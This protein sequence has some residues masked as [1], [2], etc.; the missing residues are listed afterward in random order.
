[1]IEFSYLML[2][3][4]KK[5]LQQIDCTAAFSK[6]QHISATCPAEGM[7]DRLHNGAIAN[8]GHVS[9]TVQVHRHRS[10]ILPRPT[11][12]QVKGKH[13][14]DF[15]FPFYGHWT[16]IASNRR[17]WSA[18]S[19]PFNKRYLFYYF[20]FCYRPSPKEKGNEGIQWFDC[21]KRWITKTTNKKNALKCSFGDDEIWH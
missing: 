7:V 16:A 5:K 20:M 8:Y 21:Y 1:M 3:D 6:T 18:S 11:M 13:A 19:L 17:L 4:R 12:Q 10:W 2:R 15:P 9:A 14:K